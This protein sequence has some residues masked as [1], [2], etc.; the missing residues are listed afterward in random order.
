MCFYDQRFA[1]SSNLKNFLFSQKMR[2]T[3]CQEVAKL[4]GGKM[5]KELEEKIKEPEFYPR[6]QW[7][8]H[9]YEN[10]SEAKKLSMIFASI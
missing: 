9:N 1:Q 4:R 2:H 3:T 5:L 6:L 10:S 8:K 7:A